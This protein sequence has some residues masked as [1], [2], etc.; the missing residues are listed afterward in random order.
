MKRGASL[1][2]ALVA[3]AL[4]SGCESTPG[5]AAAGQRAKVDAFVALTSPVQVPWVAG[6][7]AW[8]ACDG[9][10]GAS[11]LLLPFCFV[12]YLVAHTGIAV[13]HAADLVVTPIHLVAGNGPPGIYRGCEFPLVRE[14]SLAS[15]K[16]GELALYGAAGI[17]GVF[18]AYWFTT[19]YVPALARHLTGS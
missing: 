7:E 19:Y 5:T 9:E 1:A 15:R 8:E 11:K 10:G 2:A 16:T 14:T 3:A 18:I 12:G 17:G 4:L 6:R 13:L